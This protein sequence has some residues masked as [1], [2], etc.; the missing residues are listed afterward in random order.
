MSGT[1]GDDS[2]AS[3]ADYSQ[4]VSLSKDKYDK[5]IKEFQKLKSNNSVLKK[6]VITVRKLPKSLFF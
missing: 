5:L 1:S 4:I 2:T 3:A 6:A